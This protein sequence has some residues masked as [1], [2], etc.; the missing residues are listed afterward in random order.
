MFPA[1]SQVGPPSRPTRLPKTLH[2]P[3][4]SW[5]FW[6]RSAIRSWCSPWMHATVSFSSSVSLKEIPRGT[7][8]SLLHA[9]AAHAVLLYIFRVLML[10]SL[11]YYSARPRSPRDQQFRDLTTAPR[12][13]HMKSRIRDAFINP[14]QSPNSWVGVALQPHAGAR[15][16]GASPTPAP[17]PKPCRA[18][19][20]RPADRQSNRPA[21]QKPKFI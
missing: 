20:P 19:S 21:E 6:R 11:P 2:V 8:A 7:A 13:Q 16:D 14:A 17:A 1:G 4:S 18:R 9:H 3:S 15:H 12:H 10:P 5:P